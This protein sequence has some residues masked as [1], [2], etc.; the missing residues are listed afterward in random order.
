MRVKDVTGEVYGYLEALEI[1]DEKRGN[2]YKWKF[3]CNNCGGTYL[4]VPSD[5]RQTMKKGI[6]PSCG[7]LQGNFKHGKRH[8]KLYRTWLNIRDRCNNPNNKQYKDYGGR[9]IIVCNDWNDFNNFEKWAIDNNY[10]SK[11]TIDRIDNNRGYSPD[12]CRWVTMKEQSYNKRDNV[13]MVATSPTGEEYYVDRYTEFIEE[14]GLTRCLVY[15]CLKGK[16]HHHK[17]WKFRYR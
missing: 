10:S 12:N 9:G 14:H 3:R 8:T 15:A 17:G 4:A 2:A 7:C 1:T 16:Q 13:K 6:E 11:L 5:V